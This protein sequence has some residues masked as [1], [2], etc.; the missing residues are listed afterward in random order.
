[1]TTA[2]IT[3]AKFRELTRTK[4]ARLGLDTGQPHGDVF[5]DEE[6]ARSAAYVEMMTGQ[7]ATDSDRP[8]LTET[9]MGVAPEVVLHT[10]LRQAIQ[11][12][13]EQNAYQAQDG[14]VGDASDDVVQTLSVGGYSQSRV[15]TPKGLDR[16]LNSWAALADILW[17]LMTPAKYEYWII[18]LSGGK[19]VSSMFAP[20]W[21]FENSFWQ[22]FG[23]YG[24]CWG[25]RIPIEAFGGGWGSSL[26][27]DIG[28]LDSMS[29]ND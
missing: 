18:A 28:P 11:M 4:T 14:Y 2:Y 16:E 12:R 3:P 29:E 15:A 5:L 10:L 6:L 17:M 19:D 23:S 27:F 22:P 20:A 9:A 8:V 13:T 24:G 21:S 25:G 26:P 1:M 7:P